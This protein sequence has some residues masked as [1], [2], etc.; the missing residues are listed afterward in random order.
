MKIKIRNG[1]VCSIETIESVEKVLG[2]QFAT[3]YREFVQQYNGGYPEEPSFDVKAAN[4][5]SGIENFI[6]VE[7]I[8][9]AKARIDGLPDNAVPIVRASCGD[10][11]FINKDN[12]Q[13]FY[14]DHEEEP[15]I[16]FLAKTFS[17][18]LDM[19]Y[20]E[21]DVGEPIGKITFSNPNFKPKFK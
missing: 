2:Y 17:E 8:Q 10:I 6:L 9:E 4:S 16:H 7:E 19:L 18:F 13:I 20:P 3:D 15:G 11:V 21:P 14:W 1:S 5:T 12:D